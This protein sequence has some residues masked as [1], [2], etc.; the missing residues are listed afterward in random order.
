MLII[1][2]VCSMD[3]HHKKK[4]N[5]SSFNTSNVTNMVQMFN[6]C[7]SLIELNLSPFNTS[8][9]I[10]KDKMFDGCSN[11]LKKKIKLQYKNIKI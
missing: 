2:L 10:Y 3:V 7:S 5:L 6:G 11:K 9:V 1:C 8:K 4:L